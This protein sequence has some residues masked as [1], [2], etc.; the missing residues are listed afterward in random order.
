MGMDQMYRVAIKEEIPSVIR[1][2]APF[3]EHALTKPGPIQS[4]SK[5]TSKHFGADD[6]I[7]T[8]ERNR[9]QK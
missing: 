5:K 9:L 3:V 2:V 8:S 7:V 6:Y 4:F 1:I